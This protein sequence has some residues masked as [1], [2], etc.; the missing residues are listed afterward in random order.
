MRFVWFAVWRA[1]ADV[2]NE[3]VGSL[4]ALRISN[5]VR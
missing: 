5:T 1:A 3:S 4:V 2:E